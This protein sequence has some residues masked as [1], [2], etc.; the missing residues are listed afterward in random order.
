[1]TKYL[2]RI[3]IHHS[4]RS[5]TSYLST[6]ISNPQNMGISR[7]KSLWRSTRLFFP[8]SPNKN[9]K[10]RSRDKTN[11]STYRLDHTH[12][13]L[14]TLHGFKAILMVSWSTANFSLSFTGT[15]GFGRLINNFT[16]CFNFTASIVMYANFISACSLCTA[17][18][19]VKTGRNLGEMQW[20][21]QIFML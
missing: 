14:S 20:C 6:P 2:P 13:D 19:F 21:E 15:H 5:Y 3:R 11:H 16:R 10:K 1:M 7:T 8:P 17:I 12:S 18:Y 4:Y 9:G